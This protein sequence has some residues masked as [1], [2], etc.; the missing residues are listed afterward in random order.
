MPESGSSKENQALMLYHSDGALD[1][2]IGALLLNLGLDVLN[3]GSSVSLFTWIPILVFTSIKNRF[4]L[5]RLASKN[6][7]IDEKQ[8]RYWTTQSAVGLA[9]V[10]L[11]ASMFI[12]GDPL[13]LQNKI[14]L[15]WN[16]DVGVLSFG[17]IC[18]A[19]LL[20]AGWLTK[21]NRYYYYAAAAMGVSL[22]S[23]FLLPPYA[24]VFICAAIT[25]IFGFRI[26]NK[27]TREYPDPESKE[28]LKQ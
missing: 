28:N 20:A 1:I 5:P 8:A 11:L 22:V 16:G 3:Q 4:T 19:G 24:P 27:F 18:A 9:I 14:T 6:I 12:L 10:L 25:L 7:N 2:I 17:L 21:Y 15:P 26:M 13:D 23:S